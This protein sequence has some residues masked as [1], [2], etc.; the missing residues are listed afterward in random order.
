[1]FL[2]HSIALDEF[3]NFGFE[4]IS[5]ERTVGLQFRENLPG[6]VAPSVA[7]LRFF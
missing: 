1:M 2:H 6:E 4:L 7:P 5:I 3:Y